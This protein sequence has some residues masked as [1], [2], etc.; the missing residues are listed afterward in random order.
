MN[1]LNENFEKNKKEI[2]KLGTQFQIVTQ[3]TSLIVLDAIEDYVAYEILPPKELQG[4]YL[5][6]LEEKRKT[7]QEEK[8]DREEYEIAIDDFQ[9]KNELFRQNWATYWKQDSLQKIERHRSDSARR[10]EQARIDSIRRIEQA[11]IDSIRRVEQ[12]LKDSIRKIERIVLDSLRLIEIQKEHEEQNRLKQQKE[13]EIN[14]SIKTTYS[15]TPKKLKG[16]IL[17]SSDGMPLPG[18]NVILKASTVGVISDFDGKF[19]LN[20]PENAIIQ[21]SFV[22]YQTKTIDTKGKTNISVQLELDH[23]TLDEVVVVGYAT[24][25]KAFLTGSVSS[26]T[27][28]VRIRK[29]IKSEGETIVKYKSKIE[30]KDWNPKSYYLDSL[31]QF[32]KEKQYSAYLK[33][34][35]NYLLSPSFYFD[36]ASYF[37]Q[38]KDTATAILIASN[39]AELKLS[40]HTIL[41]VLGRKLMEFKAFD[42]AIEVFKEV[43]DLRSFEPHSYRD[44]G[45]AYEAAGEYQEAI[46]TLY[47]AIDMKW[48]DE[49]IEKYDGI[50][51]IILTELN[52]VIQKS[53]KKLDTSFINS[54]FLDFVPLDIRVVVEWDADDTDMDLW[55]TDPN[56]EKC[57]YDHS[58]TRIGGIVSEDLTEGYGPEE[59][60]L[61]NAISGNYKVEIDYFGSTKQRIQGPVNLKATF[62]TNYGKPN[63][64]QQT[65]TFRLKNKKDVIHIGNLN[66]DPK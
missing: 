23:K 46:K 11:R 60:C 7:L 26:V 30:L 65:L 3:T 24:Q 17:D 31:K 33:L 47:H 21:I 57:F 63:E 58:K 48:S 59:F 43:R 56:G 66:F 19:E 53:K 4:A 40:D 28:G 39:L 12:T 1:F 42:A 5:K 49:M 38:Q 35:T 61:K 9:Y 54:K 2:T 6:L 34:K 16:I 18:V 25:K 13:K 55:I 8:E 22:G 32:P 36:V 37:A 52:H 62:F 27:S 51:A 14:D 44:L 10:V 15:N 45:L 50:Q 29:K 41:R 20:C 64:H